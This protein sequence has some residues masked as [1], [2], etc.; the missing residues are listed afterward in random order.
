MVR[1]DDEYHTRA[2]AVLTANA[3]RVVKL[4]SMYIQAQGTLLAH[5]FFLWRLIPVV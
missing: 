1:K 5:T 3:D 2:E 4:L